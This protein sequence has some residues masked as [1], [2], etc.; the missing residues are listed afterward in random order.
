MAIEVERWPDNTLNFTRATFC[1]RAHAS[2]WLANSLPD[3]Q[4][5]PADVK[6]SFR[7]RL[8]EFGFASLLFL[9][10]AFAML[11][12]YRLMRFIGLWD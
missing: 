3:P 7:D 11:G 6:W 9:I 5:S 1:T 2:E 10:A 12:V 4:L 8:F